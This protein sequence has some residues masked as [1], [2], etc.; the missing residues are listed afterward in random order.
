MSY[1]LGLIQLFRQ[2][3]QHSSVPLSHVLDLSLMVF[4][5]LIQGLFQLGHLLLSFGSEFQRQGRRSSAEE[6]IQNIDCRES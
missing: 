1:P 6:T 3:L 5:L 4:G 2:L